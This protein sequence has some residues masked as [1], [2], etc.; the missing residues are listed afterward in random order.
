MIREYEEKDFEAIRM[1]H[2]GSGLPSNCFPDPH[3]PNFCV[4]LVAE[5][6][7]RVV[8]AAM[9]RV[10]GEGYVLVD[11]ASATPEKRNEILERMIARGLMESSYRGLDQVTAWIPPLLEKSFGKRLENLGFMRSPWPSF[12]ANIKGVR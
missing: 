9:V 4:R 2:I 8:E 7:G 12:T 5:E 6:N 3:D 1:M 10:V 11:H